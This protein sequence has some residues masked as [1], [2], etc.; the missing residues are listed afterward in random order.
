MRHF[1][2]KHVAFSNAKPFL[3]FAGNAPFS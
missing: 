2:P 3:T 1:F